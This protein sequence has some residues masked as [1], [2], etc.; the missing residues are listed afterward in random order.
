[1]A[2][3]PSREEI[4]QAVERHVSRR[5]AG[6]A[7][8]SAGAADFSWQSVFEC[9]I[10]RSVERR[11]ETHRREKGRQS[12]PAK[13]ATYTDLD[14]HPVPPPGDPART[15]RF[16]LVREGTLDELVCE[17]CEGGRKDCDV[18]AGRGGQD[19][20]RHVECEVCHGG[21]DACWECDGTGH[22]R[23]R[24]GRKT[25][26][27]PQGA[28]EPERAACRRCR[29]PDVACPNCLGERQTR[30]PVC[31]G[32]GTA[33]CTACKGAKRVRDEAC[34]GTGRFTVWTEGVIT[35]T[36]HTEE[37]K[38]SAPPFLRIRTDKWHDRTLNT[39]D[40]ELPGFLE[41]EHHKLAT[42]LLIARDGEI[43]RRVT[44]RYLPL[45]RIA[46][47]TDPDRVYYAYPGPD[48][49]V[50]CR[51]PSKER[52]TALAWAVLTVIA[53][54]TVVALTLLR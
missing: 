29:R 37:T 9:R 2:T 47:R 21:P 51:R 30:C 49:I 5:G 12:A 7:L 28:E 6:V 22:P 25:A 4:L 17:D 11:E 33:P 48:D 13:R 31:T 35:R 40:A 43:R 34:G 19:C 14:T 3:T 53:L 16:V 46:V 42:R 52:L 8:T 41:D 18:C 23:S 45:A 39:V 1:M 20:P 10:V 36:P 32:S 54:V 15:Q 27:R 38:V 26:V 50:V 24:R 44:I